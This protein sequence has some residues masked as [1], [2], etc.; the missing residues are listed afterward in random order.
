MRKEALMLLVAAFAAF[1]WMTI[2]PGRCGA[3]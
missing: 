2:V 3:G 1:L